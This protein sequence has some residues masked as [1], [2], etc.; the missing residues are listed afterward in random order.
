MRHC[1]QHAA[2]AD[3][4]P[5]ARQRH[6]DALHKVQAC[7]AISRT[8]AGESGHSILQSDVPDGE[9]LDWSYRSGGSTLLSRILPVLL[10]AH[11]AKRSIVIHVA[12]GGAQGHVVVLVLPVHWCAYSQAATGYLT[13]ACLP[14][15]SAHHGRARGSHP[16]LQEAYWQQEGRTRDHPDCAGADLQ[17]LWLEH[18]SQQHSNGG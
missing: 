7:D 3:N 8:K 17:R 12:S 6:L 15:Q 5:S 2:I 11:Q 1:A 18:P 4:A 9:K 13:S 16:H 14:L 10:P